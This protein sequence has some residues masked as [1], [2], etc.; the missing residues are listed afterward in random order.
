VAWAATNGSGQTR[1]I[2]ECRAPV[3]A[4]VDASRGVVILGGYATSMF[5]LPY[6]KGGTIDYIKA[7]AMDYV[8]AGAIE[9][10]AYLGNGAT[11]APRI[12]PPVEVSRD[13]PAALLDAAFA[14]LHRSSART[15]AKT[16]RAADRFA[17]LLADDDE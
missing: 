9:F 5:P 16:R 6:V 8:K 14:A 11:Y 7:G 12:T 2:V 4:S 3:N 1:W 10:L 15:K 13:Q 17:S